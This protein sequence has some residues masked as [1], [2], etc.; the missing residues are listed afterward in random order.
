MLVDADGK[1]VGI[2][3]DSDLARLF[4]RRRDDALDRPIQEVM[5]GQP[6]T[7]QVGTR[8]VDAVEVLQRRKI[9]ELPVVDGQGKPVGLVGHHR[10]DRPGAARGSGKLAAGGL[11][12]K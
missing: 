9:S 3:T 2:F 7:V 10:P 1:L 8:M 6:L 11:V 4:E 5:T 12:R